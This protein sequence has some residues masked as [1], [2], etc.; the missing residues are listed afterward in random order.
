MGRHTNASLFLFHW[1]SESRFRDDRCRWIGSLEKITR[2]Q[3]WLSLA[4][5]D[6]WPG[7][8]NHP[9]VTRHVQDKALYTYRADETAISWIERWGCKSA[10]VNARETD[11]GNN[12]VL[13]LNIE[14]RYFDVACINFNLRLSETFFYLLRIISQK[15]NELPI[16]Q[17]NGN[18]SNQTTLTCDID[19]Q[20][21]ILSKRFRKRNMCGYFIYLIVVWRFRTRRKGARKGKE[22]TE[23]GQRGKRETRNWG[24]NRLFSCELC[25][26][27]EI[28]FCPWRRC[29]KLL[30]LSSFS[31]EKKIYIV[32]HD[33]S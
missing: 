6:S 19:K 18:K 3:F 27:C 1:Q 16:T 24:E 32:Y 20:I 28:C 5:F 25:W 33:A 2:P 26:L 10:T 7:Y 13:H 15:F 11:F 4:A 8:V 21:I 14:F 29:Q 9:R 22:E 12:F 30:L 31:T 17:I 23:T